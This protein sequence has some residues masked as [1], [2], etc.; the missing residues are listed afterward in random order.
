MHID[1]NTINDN[2]VSYKTCENN[3]D[4]T[5]NENTLFDDNL[6]KLL[7]ILVENGVNKE[8]R[9][10][11]IVDLVIEDPELNSIGKA[12]KK[13]NL[14]VALRPKV[15]NALDSDNSECK[16]ET[17]V[18]KFTTKTTKVKQSLAELCSKTNRARNRNIVGL[19]KKVRI[20]SLH[21]LSK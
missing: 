10:T 16:I 21:K 18:S 17:P 14:E 5:T 4:E 15:N 13:S 6:P 20:D 3:R 9:K 8:T 11:N 19:S 12:K 7:G 2:L 1:K